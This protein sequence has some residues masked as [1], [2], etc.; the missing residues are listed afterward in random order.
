MNKIYHQYDRAIDWITNWAVH[1]TNAPSGIVALAI[2]T[3]AALALTSLSIL[4]LM[5]Y[6]RPRRFFDRTLLIRE[7]SLA[8]LW[9][10]MITDFYFHWLNPYEVRA[11]Y[12]FIIVTN[13]LVFIALIRERWFLE[14]DKNV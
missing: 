12:L 9:I 14:D 7:L 10:T 8:L 1:V 3:V 13:V 4:S 5:I 6:Y 2:I 11:V